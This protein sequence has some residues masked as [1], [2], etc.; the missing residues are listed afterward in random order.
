M[1]K[2]PRPSVPG[3]SEMTELIR[4]LRGVKSQLNTAVEE[5]QTAKVESN[6][7]KRELGERLKEMHDIQNV[8]QTLAT[9]SIEEK[10]EFSIKSYLQLVF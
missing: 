8:F 1:P 2:S 5:K 3:V 4:E 10:F 7:F 9:V 6:F